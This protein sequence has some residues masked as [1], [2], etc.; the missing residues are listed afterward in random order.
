MKIG[1]IYDDI[2]RENLDCSNPF[3]G[4]P[5]VGGTQFCYL[6]LI[7]YL[8]VL[9]P[10]I[11]IIVYRYKD[12]CEAV[13]MP[14]EDC[15]V[16]KVLNNLQECVY[17]AGEDN[18]DLLLFTFHHAIELAPI[19]EERRI[20]SV[21]WIHNWI[22]GEVLTAISKCRFIKRAVFLVREHYDRYIDDDVIKK[23]VYIPN[24]FTTEDYLETIRWHHCWG[25]LTPTSNKGCIK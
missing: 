9:Y 8:S 2:V 11:D 23:A 21:V 17:Q 25:L 19:I 7:Y 14:K 22:R 4:N 12:N 3:K 6:N 20:S 16:Y 5:G 1:M 24:M 18:V 13:K 10:E 15:V